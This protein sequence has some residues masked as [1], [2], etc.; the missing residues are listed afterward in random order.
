VGGEE[1]REGAHME[2]GGEEW[3]DHMEARGEEVLGEEGQGDHEEEELGVRGGEGGEM[4]EGGVEGEDHM[5]G[6]EAL[7]GE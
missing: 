1:G 6:G 3:G 4:R 7:V 2:E 5:E